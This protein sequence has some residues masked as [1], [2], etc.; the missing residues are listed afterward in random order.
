MTKKDSLILL[1]LS[2]A[3]LLMSAFVL[4][5]FG[6]SNDIVES[7]KTTNNKSQELI[8]IIKSGEKPISNEQVIE[9]IK[10]DINES[11]LVS[12]TFSSIAKAIRSFAYFVIALVFIQG[13]IVIKLYR[14]GTS[15]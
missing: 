2:G 10:N 9:V 1:S 14:K 12:S 13:F 8:A 15:A 11:K 6:S 4:F 3:L 7:Y 5:A